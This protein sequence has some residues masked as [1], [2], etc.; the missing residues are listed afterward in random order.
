MIGRMAKSVDCAVAAPVGDAQQLSP[1]LPERWRRHV[2]TFGTRAPAGAVVAAPAARALAED[3]AVG[4]LLPVT[5]APV[6]SNLEL[7]AAMAA[8]VNDWQ[9]AEWLGRDARLRGS[10]VVAHEDAALAV[11][12]IE[13]RAGDRR[14]VQVLFPG[15]AHAPLGD[16]RYRLVLAAAERHGLPVCVAALAQPH[17]VSMVF[18]AVFEELPKL[19]VLCLGGCGWVPPLTWRLDGSW[20]VLKDEVPELRRLPSEYVR[21]HVWFDVAPEDAPHLE[22]IVAHLGYDDRLVGD[23]FE[24][25]ARALHADRL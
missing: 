15:P 3:V 25:N 11:E 22:R 8:A 7:A 9:V 17:L 5:E 10:I 14:F 24:R 20:K 6:Q 12:E 1:Y 16:R 23:G 13:R 19:R 4:V 18:G 21:E 2:A